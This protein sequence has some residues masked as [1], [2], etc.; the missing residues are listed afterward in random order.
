MV[1]TLF[2]LESNGDNDAEIGPTFL[3]PLRYEWLHVMW[4]SMLLV[5]RRRDTTS[6]CN[7]KTCFDSITKIMHPMCSLSGTRKVLTNLHE[8]L[9]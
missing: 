1:P 5:V 9:A 8:K 7:C 6:T 2:Q 4:I 3:I